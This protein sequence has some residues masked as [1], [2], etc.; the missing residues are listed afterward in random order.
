VSRTLQAADVRSFTIAPSDPT[1]LYLAARNRRLGTKTWPG[2]VYRS[3]DGGTTWRCVLEDDFVQGLAVHPR[4][5]DVVYA[6]LTDHPY[7]DESTGDGVVLTRDGGKT[8]SNISGSTLT[9][10]HVNCISLDPR[11][12]EVVYLGT[13]GNGVFVGRVT[14]PAATLP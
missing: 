4:D 2:G 9:C 14:S 3:D 10:K 12:P 11:D 7:H 6:G 5:P 8:W 1:R 13:G